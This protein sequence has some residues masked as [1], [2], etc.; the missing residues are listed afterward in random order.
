[1]RRISF[2]HLTLLVIVSAIAVYLNW[3]AIKASTSLFN[4]IIV[5]P[6]GILVLGLALFVFLSNKSDVDSDVKA[7]IGDVTLLAIFAIFCIS[8][9]TVGFDIATFLFV[10]LSI[11]I[12]GSKNWFV[13]PLYSAIFTFLLVKGFGSLFP[14][15]LPLMV[16]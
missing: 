5:V 6:S 3:S 10:W 14:F 15:P 9:T 11:I 1:M 16:F 13:P 4:L 12:G 7:L 8:L 2:S